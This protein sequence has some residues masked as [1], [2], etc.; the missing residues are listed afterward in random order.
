MSNIYEKIRN[1]Q[2]EY[3]QLLDEHFSTERSELEPLIKANE[4]IDDK[5]YEVAHRGP[6]V[7]F[8]GHQLPAVTYKAILLIRDIHNFWQENRSALYESIIQIPHLKLH[9]KSSFQTLLDEVRSTAL[10]VD[11][12]VADDWLFGMREMLEDRERPQQGDLGVNV[13]REY[14][15]LQSLRELSSANV[16]PPILI[17]CPSPHYADSELRKISTGLSGWLALKYASELYGRDFKDINEVIE[18]TIKIRDIPSLVKNISDP[19]LI[20]EEGKN[21]ES[22]IEIKLFAA[23]N[24]LHISGFPAEAVDLNPGMAIII[25]EMAGFDIIAQ[26]QIDNEILDL[27]PR[28]SPYHW[29]GYLWSLSHGNTSTE[30]SNRITDETAVARIL[31]LPELSWLGNVPSAKLVELRSEGQMEEMRSLIRNSNE[32][33]KYI[34]P[35]EFSSLADETKST[36]EEAL[37]KHESEIKSDTRK[38]RKKLG[39]ELA[40]FVVSGSIAAASVAVPLLAIPAAVIGLGAGAGSVRDVIKQIKHIKQQS[41]KTAGRPLGILWDAFSQRTQ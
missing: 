36:L 38:G 34:N 9:A 7:S 32:K 33:L 3:F 29:D 17:V 12:I 15:Y 25:H 26:Q 21:L 20:W 22:R 19:N 5:A 16:V 41:N 23:A 24:S 30:K 11:T 4:G 2:E 35:D 31:E 28:V 37:R 6:L 40:A 18:Y 10:Y 14:M 1:I 13:L 8:E 27:E 39:F